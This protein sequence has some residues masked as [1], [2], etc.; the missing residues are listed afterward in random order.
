MKKSAEIASITYKGYYVDPKIQDKEFLYGI[1]AAI[2]FAI[3]YRLLVAV[4]PNIADVDCL[5][6]EQILS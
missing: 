4:Y 5:E 3:S 1:Y 2:K 6:L